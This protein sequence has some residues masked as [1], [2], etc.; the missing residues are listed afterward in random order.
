MVT[1]PRI[2]CATGSFFAGLRLGTGNKLRPN[3]GA[4]MVS[5]FENSKQLNVYAL[6]HWNDGTSR[7]IEVFFCK[8]CVL[9]RLE[10]Y[11]WKTAHLLY[12]LCKGWEFLENH[13]KN[14]VSAGQAGWSLSQGWLPHSPGLLQ[15]SFEVQQATRMHLKKKLIWGDCWVAREVVDLKLFKL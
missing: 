11:T 5:I 12:D 1:P 15:R 9:I 6:D 8:R 10:C 2:S 4:P 13:S 3:V 14:S 7:E